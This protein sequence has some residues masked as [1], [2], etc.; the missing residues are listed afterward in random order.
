MDFDTAMLLALPA[1]FLVF[2]GLEALFPS[3]REMPRIRHWRLVG[4]AGFALTL[5]VLVFVPLLIVPFLPPMASS[6]YRA[7][8]IGQRSRFGC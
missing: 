6:T 8:A 4:L 1:S 2:L 7:G 3:K 5:V